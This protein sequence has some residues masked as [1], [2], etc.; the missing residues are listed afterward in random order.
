[1]KTNYQLKNQPRIA[2]RVATEL[3]LVITFTNSVFTGSSKE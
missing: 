1:M 2:N 3:F